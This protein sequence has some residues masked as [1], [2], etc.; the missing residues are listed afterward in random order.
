MTFIERRQRVTDTSGVLVLL[1]LTAP[2][3]GATL[4]LVNDTQDW[5]S[6]GQTYIGFPFRFQPPEDTAGQSPRGAIEID[7]IGRGITADLESWQ[8]GQV[9]NARLMVAD[10]A[11][12]HTYMVDM[13]LPI[14]RV[15]TNE[16]VARAEGGWDMLLRQQVSRLRYTPYVAPGMF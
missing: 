14:M 4:R 15:T 16:S 10:R 11:D 2:S 1:E 7:N 12:P 3:L 13:P 9:L 8:P 6:N 5:V